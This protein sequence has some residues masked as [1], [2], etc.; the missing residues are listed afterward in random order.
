MY[1]KFLLR[2]IHAGSGEREIPCYGNKP[3]DSCLESLHHDFHLTGTLMGDKLQPVWNLTSALLLKRASE[4]IWQLHFLK[5]HSS[6]YMLWVFIRE[7]MLQNMFRPAHELGGKR[8]GRT[9]F[10]PSSLVAFWLRDSSGC[11]RLYPRISGAVTHKVAVR[12]HPPG[13]APVTPSAGWG[14]QSHGSA[15]PKLGAE[16]TEH[17]GPW[18]LSIAFL[19]SFLPAL[20]VMALVWVPHLL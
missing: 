4:K 16:V 1:L 13:G 3:L 17:C 20:T 14:Q 10:L 19:F 15:E 6:C 2:H 18:K 12:L 7:K 8:G 11:C 9:F 5:N